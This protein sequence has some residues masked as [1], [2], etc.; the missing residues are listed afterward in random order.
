MV[1]IDMSTRWSHICL[2]STQNVA[3]ARLLAQIIRLRTQL[4]DHSI[5]T[6]C[7]YNAGAFLSQ[8][9]CNYCMSLVLDVQYLVAHVHTHNRLLESFIKRLQLIARQLLLKNKLPLAA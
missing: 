2:L 3:F 9:F 7:L 4:P 8:A 6:I 5:K 1:L